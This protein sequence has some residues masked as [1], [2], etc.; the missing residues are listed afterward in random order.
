MAGRIAPTEDIQ[1]VVWVEM[2]EGLPRGQISFNFCKII[3]TM[4]S[5]AIGTYFCLMTVTA[6]PI[7]S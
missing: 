5:R 7:L 1:L 6:E 2:E 4:I 3:T